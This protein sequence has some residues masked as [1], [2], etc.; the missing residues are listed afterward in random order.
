MYD[1]RSLPFGWKLSP[2]LCRAVVGNHVRQAFDIMT[3][4]M[5]AAEIVEYDHYLDDVLVVREGPPQWVHFGISN[6]LGLQ[7]GIIV[8]LI[9]I[10]DNLNCVKD[11]QR[12][13]GLINWM[14]KPATG[15]LPCFGGVYCAVVTSHSGWLRVAQGMWLSLVSAMFVATPP[16]GVPDCFVHNWLLLKWIFADAA[17]FVAASGKTMY[18]IGIF[19]PGGGGARA[20]VCP[21]WVD[22]QQIAELYGV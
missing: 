3:S 20:L 1:L 6:L 21:A 14:A 17:E 4:A 5:P 22:N 19:D 16:F 11:L 10:F 15:H 9:K 18:R 2:P 12:V 7:A 8:Y 13:M